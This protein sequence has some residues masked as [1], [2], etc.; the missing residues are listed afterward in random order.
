M[1]MVISRL[2]RHFIPVTWKGSGR[3]CGAHRKV[4]SQLCVYDAFLWYI[5]T[6]RSFCRYSFIQR[7]VSPRTCPCNATP[8]YSL[9]VR[10]PPTLPVDSKPLDTS[11]EHSVY[12]YLVYLLAF[13]L[14]HRPRLI[15]TSWSQT[16]LS[17]PSQ[18]QEEGCL[19]CTRRV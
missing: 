2:S 7:R 9:P 18:A 16:R 17:T 19:Q 11:R 6:L 4:D 13:L 8:F 1:V 3:I 14:L 15:S 12:I 10:S 5:Q